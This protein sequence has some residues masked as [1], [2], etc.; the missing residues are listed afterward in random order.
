[1]DTL[2]LGIGGGTSHILNMLFAL[3]FQDQNTNPCVW[4]FLGC[5]MDSTVGVLV[6]V[7][8]MEC[9]ERWG[10][11]AGV[12]VRGSYGDPPS[13]QRW[14]VQSFFW[15]LIVILAKICVVW[16]MYLDEDWW[17]KAGQKILSPVAYS[18][19]VELVVAMLI[20]PFLCMVGYFWIM[21]TLLKG[22]DLKALWT[23]AGRHYSKVANED[24]D[25]DEE[26]DG[27]CHSSAE[28]EADSRYGPENDEKVSDETPDGSRYS[29][30]QPEKEGQSEGQSVL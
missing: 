13:F 14:G 30:V 27:K 29:R 17:T 28:D 11:G 12:Q 1:M 23:P 8:L 16:L 19:K 25:E 2:K 22:V 24:Y 21:D 3:A 6:S 26:E 18:P 20:A 7:I 15:V 4:Y 10:Q 5:L 9:C